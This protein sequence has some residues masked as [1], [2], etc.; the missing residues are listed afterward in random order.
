MNKLRIGMLNCHGLKNKFETPEFQNLVSSHEI[1]GVCET[2]LNDNES[3]TIP[4]FNFYP[5]NRKKD[6]EITKGGTKGGIGVYIKHEYKKH[7]KVM[8]DISTEIVLWCKISKSFLNSKDET[9]LGITYVPPEYSTREKRLQKDHFTNLTEK[10]STLPTNRHILIG[11]FNARTSDREDRLTREKHDD[12]N[13][14]EL[15]SHIKKKRCNLDTVEN[16]YG[17]L[18]LE[19]TAATQSYIANGRTLGD[20]QGNLTCHETRGS[21][22]VDYAIVSEA[23]KKEVKKFKVLPPSV[24]SD[25]CP[26]ELEI[27]YHASKISKGKDNLTP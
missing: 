21:S 8:Y 6:K 14:P 4:G 18:L 2:W 19:L 13:P 22:T 24:G 5:L 1:F 9:N 17:K 27:S 25:H 10:L 12:H 23:L 7:V 15:F 20:L 26:I 16:R 3:A 11:D